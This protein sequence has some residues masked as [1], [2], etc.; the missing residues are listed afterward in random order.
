MKATRVENLILEGP[1]PLKLRERCT[2]R[3]TQWDEV[4]DNDT[5]Q[6][7]W[8]ARDVVTE[9]FEEV[10]PDCWILPR[11]AASLEELEEMGWETEDVPPS[12]IPFTY[13]RGPIPRDSVQEIS[14]EEIQNEGT[15]VLPPGSGKTAIFLAAVAHSSQP[16]LIFVDNGGL[17]TQWMHAAKKHLGLSSDEIGSLQGPVASWTAD[18]PIVIGMYSSVTQALERGDFPAELTT[19]FGWVCW[20]EA[21]TALTPTR[22]ILLSLFHARRVALSATPEKRG[23]E[24]LL[25]LHAGPIRV[26]VRKGDLEPKV[27]IAG[28][29]CKAPNISPSNTR[30]YLKLM[31][32]S[33]GGSRKGPN[34]AYLD[35]IVGTLRMLYDEGRKIMVLVPRSG[36]IRAIKDLIPDAA[37]LDQRTPFFARMDRLNASNIVLVSTQIGEKGLDREDLDTLVVVFPFGKTAEGRFRQA[38]GRVLRE[39]PNKPTPEVY[40]YYPD[41]VYGRQLGD[42]AEGI[43]KSLGWETNHSRAARN[44]GRQS[45]VSA[46]LK[47]SK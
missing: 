45:R 17:F 9:A 18:R 22:F 43:S 11:H 1:L 30:A 23:L 8:S 14:I 29:P 37:V 33:L 31:S 13:P 38:A 34:P 42:A 44:T 28:I 7:V 19:R 24:E 12:P 32:H 16:A 3:T 41:S 25:Y 26:D 5:S 40:F 4:L 20:D 47:L 15:L 39:Y 36:A 10:L 46:A 6:M 27:H 21:P 35:A 2:V